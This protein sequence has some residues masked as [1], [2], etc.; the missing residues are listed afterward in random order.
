MG[1]MLC[2]LGN[3]GFPFCH[4]IFCV[5]SLLLLFLNTLKSFWK[6][7]K[8]IIH[9]VFLTM[10]KVTYGGFVWTIFFWIHLFYRFCSD[11]KKTTSSNTHLTN[12]YIS[13]HYYAAVPK[14]S[15]CTN[16][17]LKGVQAFW[18]GTIKTGNG[19]SRG[20]GIHNLCVLN[21]RH[22]GH[23]TA[24]TEQGEEVILSLFLWRD[25]PQRIRGLW[26]NAWK[27]WP[28]WGGIKME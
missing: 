13:L 14:T 19:V 15:H 22:R 1:E 24:H 4:Y 27:G 28:V 26:L 2:F 25:G 3:L 10:C 17:E 18:R 6:Y 5:Q 9:H 8:S 21:L 20:E 12:M 23:F 11:I 7:L 16:T